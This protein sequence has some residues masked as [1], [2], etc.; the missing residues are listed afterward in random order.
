MTKERKRD[1]MVILLQNKNRTDLTIIMN[2]T[3]K[4]TLDQLEFGNSFFDRKNKD[5]LPNMMTNHLH[6]LPEYYLVDFLYYFG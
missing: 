2:K 4:E 3:S 1:P 6:M 5:N